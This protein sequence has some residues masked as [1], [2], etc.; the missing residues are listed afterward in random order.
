[1]ILNVR[2][3]GMIAE[4]VK[5]ENEKIAL[6]NSVSVATFRKELIKKYPALKNA[7][8]QIAVDQELVGD[9]FKIESD[10]EIALLPPFAGG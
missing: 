7:N 3:F 6:E 10:C 1:M 2:Y 4:T 8:Y 9:E 5:S